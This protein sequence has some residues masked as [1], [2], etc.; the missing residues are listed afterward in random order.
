MSA[1]SVAKNTLQIFKFYHRVD[2]KMPYGFKFCGV[3]PHCCGSREV[4]SKLIM[5]STSPK[6]Q[7]EE[8]SRDKIQGCMQR[9]RR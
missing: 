1:F 3:I 7:K 9:F 5:H 4:V 6:S 2:T 8:E